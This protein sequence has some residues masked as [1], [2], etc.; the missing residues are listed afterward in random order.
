MNIIVKMNQNNKDQLTSA[1]AGTAT[2]L[3]LAF[4]V[5][6]GL[7]AGA[8]LLFAGISPSLSAGSV[9]FSAGSALVSSVSGVLALK[10]ARKPQKIKKIGLTG[11]LLLGALTPVFA[12]QNMGIETQAPH[13][14]TQPPTHTPQKPLKKPGMWV[15]LNTNHAPQIAQVS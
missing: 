13:Q 9:I 2:G 11:G 3:S 14:N 5:A 15:L 4:A 8:T 12:L 6:T 10:A 7:T 1:L